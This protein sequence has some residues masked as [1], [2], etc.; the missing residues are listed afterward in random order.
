MLFEI[1]YL[2]FGQAIA[3]FSPNVLLASL[4]VPLFFT[5]SKPTNCLHVSCADSASCIILRR[6]CAIRRFAIILA[7]MDVL[8]D[9]VQV[10]SKLLYTLQ[11]ILTFIVSLKASLG[12]LF[13]DRRS[14][15]RLR[16]LRSSLLRLAKTAKHTLASLLNKQV[17]T[18]KRNQT[19][20]VGTVST[21]QAKR[22]LHLSTSS[23]RIYGA[24]LVRPRLQ[25]LV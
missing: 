20:T 25:V 22:S 3:S 14:D 11:R 1:F 17:A 19:G 12:C 8:A 24:T 4:L 5:F 16:S 21:R 2:G 15:V 6:C 23:R 7:I 9:T 10:V 13:K 18:F